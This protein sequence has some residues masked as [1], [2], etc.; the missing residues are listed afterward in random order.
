MTDVLR[1]AKT[2]KET[3]QS[4]EFSNSGLVSDP[5]DC[6][7]CKKCKASN[8]CEKTVKV[9][10]QLKQ[11][12]VKP[13]KQSIV[14]EQKK[15]DSCPQNEPDYKA[16]YEELLKNQIDARNKTCAN[17]E[18]VINT[19]ETSEMKTSKSIVSIKEFRTSQKIKL[20]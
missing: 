12:C 19:S 1:E 7:K 18:V 13:N 8:S 15:L 9:K 10:K 4:C 11:P 16:L 17:R 20:L 6:L 5:K 3:R 2:I 14:L